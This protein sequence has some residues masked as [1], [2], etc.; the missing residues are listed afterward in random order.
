MT[1]L[2]DSTLLGCFT[3]YNLLTMYF[4]P[5]NRLLV[6][7]IVFGLLLQGC[8]SNFRVTSEEPASKKLRKTSDEVPIPDQV[9]LPDGLSSVVSDVPHSGFPTV[10]SV[11]SPSVAISTVQAALLMYHLAVE[12]DAVSDRELASSTESGETDT[13]PAAR[14]IAQV[15]E[16]SPVG[17]SESSRVIPFSVPAPVFGAWAWARYFGEVGVAPPLPSDIGEIL[18][19][20]CPFWPGKAVKDTHLLVLIP[21]TVDGKAFTLDL[22]GELVQ[23]PRGGGHSTQYFLY[24]DEV[25]QSLGDVY[26]SS[27][28][29]VLLTR[30]V[31]P[32]SRSKPYTAQQALVAAQTAHIKCA[33]YAIPNVL[34]A[35]T[36][37]L[38]H[39]VCS[40]DRL[41]AEGDDAL[42]STSTRC[43]GLLEDAAEYPS[44]VTVGRF[45]SRGLVFFSG[46][47]DDEEFGVS[48][49]RRFGSRH[50]RPSI[51]LHSFG[52]EEWRRYFGEVG[53]APSLPSDIADILNSGCPFWPGTRV[54][55]THL[56]V[57]MP[58]T[59]NGEPFNLDLLGALIKR[60]RGRGYSTKYCY[61]D[62][63][64][65][66]QFGA[67]SPTRSY[68]VLM[69]R[70]VLEGS[71]GKTY[72]EQRELVAGHASRTGL[73]YKLPSALEAAT[74]ILAHHVR[75]GGRLYMDEQRTWTR[76]QDLVVDEGEGKYPVAVGG[77]SSGGL[78]VSYGGDG[79]DLG[80]NYIGVAGFRK[81]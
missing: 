35:A 2:Y 24:D 45:C 73:S 75:S 1:A 7:V 11:T 17:R 81:F 62:S 78:F 71:R 74:A 33:P 50:Y 36:V 47:D 40:G 3:H 37:M 22:L 80:S 43:T 76:C 16:L 48:C 8:R 26:S 9:S 72:A 57:L 29:W 77:F 15:A 31:L 38:S 10:A 13:K 4:S 44:P 55:D 42:P 21:A 14:P 32:G 51:L 46:F 19:R 5:L 56:L 20:P 54:R 59:V 27:S 49:L 30:D 68:W 28:Y 60:P 58:A 66:E 12:N 25:Q 63:D 64:I 79:Y 70:D 6:T 53:A 39:Y 23:N 61:Y 69:T 18:D 65:R 41:Y 67:R 34:E 52:V